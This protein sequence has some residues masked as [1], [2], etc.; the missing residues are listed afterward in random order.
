VRKAFLIICIFLASIVLL[1]VGIK[2]FYIVKEE[3]F[4]QQ[5]L[6]SLKNEG[7]A[8]ITLQSEMSGIPQNQREQAFKDSQEITFK[9]MRFLGFYPFIKPASNYKMVVQLA[10]VGN[11]DALTEL[12]GTTAY[13]SFWENNPREATSSPLPKGI[14]E[15]FTH[16]YKTDLNGTDLL[17]ASTEK[18]SDGKS[19]VRLTFRDTGTKKFADIT[20]RNIGKIVAIV[21]DDEIIEMPRVSEPIY[22]GSAVITGHLTAD[23]A[24][25]LQIQLNAGSLPAPITVVDKHYIK[26]GNY[27]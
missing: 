8:E 6:Q 12:I 21:L 22:G 23:Q 25:T 20:K 1:G 14:S 2:L 9:R 15:I 10:R 19:Q 27:N 11:L 24:K 13:L 5:E 7:G 26:R 18:S 4:K 17:G 16:P 3:I